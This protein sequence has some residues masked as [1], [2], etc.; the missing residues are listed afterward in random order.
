MASR[1]RV[2]VGIVGAGFVARIHAE[3]YRHVRGVEVELRVVTAAR[4]ERARAF[5]AE[6]GVARAVA[7]FRAI[8]ADPTWTWS[9]SACRRTCT[10]RWRSRPRAAG[11][12]VI[13]E[14]PLTGFF[15]PPDTPRAEMLERALAVAPTR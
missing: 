15:G 5:A 6:F 14:K 8:L 13:V 9:I 3:A 11:K 1:P 10:R 2:R 7:D 4:P 12:H